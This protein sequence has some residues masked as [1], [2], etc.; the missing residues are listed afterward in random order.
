M[1]DLNTQKTLIVRRPLSEQ[2]YQLLEDR[3]LAGTIAPGTKLA[4]EAIAEEFG[5][6]RSPAREAISQLE[7]V[8]LAEKSGPRD[9]RVVIPSRK[10]IID[11]YATWIILE[12]GR[13]YLSSLVATKDDHRRIREIVHG[14]EEALTANNMTVYQSWFSQFHTMLT[15]HCDNQLLNQALEGFERHRKWLAA[16]Y[17]SKPE[18]SSRSLIE[19]KAIAKN[20][21]KS[22]LVGITKALEAHMMRQRDSVLARLAV[23]E[24]TEH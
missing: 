13:I 20:Y 4:E 9:R 16:L 1:S 7:K 21:I 14:M 18:T 11:V 2:V 24:K 6:S 10:T 19:H 15:G 3:I 22:D 23:I 8:G 17:H 5:V 12:T